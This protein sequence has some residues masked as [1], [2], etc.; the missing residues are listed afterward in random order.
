MA[1]K[2]IIGYTA[3]E[4]NIAGILIPKKSYTEFEKKHGKK[5]YTEVD[6]NQLALLQ[7]DK[8]F[9]T[10]L[11]NKM[12]RILDHIPNFALSGEDRANRKLAEVEKKYTS[13]VE[14]L[15]AELAATKAELANSKKKN[16]TSKDSEED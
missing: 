2:Y 1:N 8:V 6:D 11:G 14:K 7:N 12:V 13:E 4:Y 15:K 16:K 9:N 10:L 3:V 5:P